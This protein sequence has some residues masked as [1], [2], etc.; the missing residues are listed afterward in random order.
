MLTTVNN[1]GGRKTHH[2]TLCALAV[3]Q[4]V[5]IGAGLRAVR[6]LR[7]HFEPGVLRLDELHSSVR[8]VLPRAHIQE[9]E[10]EPS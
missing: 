2:V 8:A 10:G 5:R 9:G 3:R 7:E 4:E 1:G 6:T